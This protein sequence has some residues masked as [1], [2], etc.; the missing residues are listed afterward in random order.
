M[1]IEVYDKKNKQYIERMDKILEELPASVSQFIMATEGSLL[2]RT[3]Y[4]YV[5]DIRNFYKYL[6]NN[7]PNFTEY[8][9]ITDEDLNNLNS[10]DFDEYLYQIRQHTDHVTESRKISAIKAYFNYLIDRKYITNKDALGIKHPKKRRD[11]NITYMDREEINNL[12]DSIETGENL[13][14][15]QRKYHQKEMQ[16]DIAIIA[17]LLGTGI[18]VSECANLDINDINLDKCYLT[19]V[20]KRKKIRSVYFSDTVKYY[21]SAYIAIRKSTETDEKDALFI[22]RNLTR[23]S[24]RSIQKL[25]KKYAVPEVVGTKHITPHKLR[26]SFGTAMLEQSNDIATVADILGHD[27]ISTTKQYYAQVQKEASIKAGRNGIF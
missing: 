25:V 14:G 1:S 20:G 10:F 11:K 22:S 15:K 21:L 24:E 27:S 23:L 13:L 17:V 4:G 19:V 16:R 5:C 3:S 2:P 8:K 9:N 6:L 18:R 26:S 12:L 7:N